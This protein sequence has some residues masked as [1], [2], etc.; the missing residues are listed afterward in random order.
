MNRGLFLLI[1]VATLITGCHMAGHKSGSLRT[2]N[3]R[4]DGYGMHASACTAVRVF[5]RCK[6]REQG[7]AGVLGAEPPQIASLKTGDLIF[8]GI[9]A[10]Y[11]LDQGSM[12]EAISA[13]T[14]SGTLNL[15]HVAIAEVCKDSV[16]IIDAT[17]KHGVDRHP[18][19]TMLKEFTLKDGSQPTY[20]VK[21]L[22]HS[23]HAAQ[24]VDNA[25][26]FLGQPYDAAFLPDNGALYCTELV[27]E[28]YRTPKGRYLFAEKPM[29][30]KNADGEFP[31]YWQQLFA[32]IGQDIPQGVPGTN[33]Q[34]MSQAACLKRAAVSF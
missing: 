30:F 15:I 22:K 29:N 8:I 11:S 24:Y 14:G 34:D 17:I 28:S 31:L 3:A 13:S 23:R 18:L 12:D 26:T 25:K 32:L 10:D 16:W 6:I 5:C 21:R 1:A 4:C 7:A 33:P 9:P 20:I 27:R 2:D 19:D